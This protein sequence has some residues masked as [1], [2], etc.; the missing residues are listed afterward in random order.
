MSHGKRADPSERVKFFT[1]EIDKLAVLNDQVNDWIKEHP[2]IETMERV[3]G[4]SGGS[5]GCTSTHVTIA[6]RYRINL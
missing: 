2:G 4:V 3:I 1:A 5:T 6:L